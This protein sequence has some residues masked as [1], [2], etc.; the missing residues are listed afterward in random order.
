MNTDKHIIDKMTELL[1]ILKEA[2]E[3]NPKQARKYVRTRGKIE[4]ALKVIGSGYRREL[5]RPESVG[6]PVQELKK[7]KIPEPVEPIGDVLADNLPEADEE[8]PKPERKPRI[9]KSV[10]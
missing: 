2:I 5:K 9:K 3:E 4:Q 6:L 10:Q 8:K 1:T 7:E